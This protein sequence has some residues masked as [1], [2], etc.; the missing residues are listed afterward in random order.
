V[1]VSTGQTVS[2]ARAIRV[3]AGPVPAAEAALTGPR[4]PAR[5]AARPVSGTA[6]VRVRVRGRT[7][8]LARGAARPTATGARPAR[9]KATGRLGSLTASRKTRSPER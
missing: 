4:D 2:T 8:R 7:G 3:L 6:L 1:T 9:S 5:R